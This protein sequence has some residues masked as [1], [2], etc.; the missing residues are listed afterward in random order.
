MCVY[1]VYASLSAERESESQNDQ[2]SSMQAHVGLNFGAFDFRK[3]FARG[4]FDRNVVFN[5]TVELFS[6]KFIWKT[7]N[8]S[9][10][11]LKPFGKE[12]NRFD[13]QS[14]SDTTTKYSEIIKK[15]HLNQKK[16]KPL[17]FQR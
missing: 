3:S 6:D 8:E 17:Q 9:S 12:I 2:T 15:K 13:L 10:G 4:L 7:R 14:K 1:F 11:V 5:A 16:H